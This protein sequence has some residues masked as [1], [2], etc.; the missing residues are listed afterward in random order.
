MKKALV[1]LVMAAIGLSCGSSSSYDVGSFLLKE[2]GPSVFRL[3]SPTNEGHGGTGF[4][5]KMPSGNVYAITNSHVCEIAENNQMAVHY[6]N[7]ESELITVIQQSN[8]TDLCI[9]YPAKKAPPL[10]LARGMD[11]FEHINVI[12]HPKLFPLAYEDGYI[13]ERRVAT[14]DA[15]I[16]LERCINSPKLTIE[17]FDTLW[18][19][20][21]I[22]V[23]KIDS[24]STNVVIYGGNSGSPALNDHG[25]V[26][27]VFFAGDNST[28]W[29][30]FVP[31]DDL[32]DFVRKF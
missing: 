24:Y 29:G 30:L 17:T 6:H 16:P 25:Q 8:E 9:L 7:G 32:K 13:L 18:G 21:T 14:L 19:E 12:G 5:L 28:N 15:E 23:L 2:K 31:L 27:G 26:I 3:T 4:N 22:C 1:V 10:E 11:R 20:V